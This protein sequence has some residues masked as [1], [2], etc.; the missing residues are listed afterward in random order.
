[1]AS[2]LEQL[3]E[4]A[5]PFATR[6]WVEGSPL[7]V[8]V[9]ARTIRG[10]PAGVLLA[11]YN[12]LS[13][14]PEGA[15]VEA[16]ASPLFLPSRSPSPVEPPP[17][18]QVSV[19]ARDPSPSPPAVLVSPAPAPAPAPAPFAPSGYRL[20]ARP[21]ASPRAVAAAEASAP[22]TFPLRAA[23]LVPVVEVPAVQDVLRRRHSSSRLPAA[24]ASGALAP[25]LATSRSADSAVSARLPRG[26]A[27]R[28]PFL[29]FG[30]SLWLIVFLFS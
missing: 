10:L 5:L 23:T 12:P 2:F 14:L 3:R 11:D 18:S 1:M 25:P 30:D 29:R 19:A 6:D 24:A 4:Q 8:G 21:R 28:L 15:P 26:S 9:Y 13:D 27:V 7:L 17:P 22:P 16:P 20:R